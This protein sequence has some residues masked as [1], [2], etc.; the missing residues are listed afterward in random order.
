MLRQLLLPRSLPP[1][2]TL[3]VTLETTREQDKSGLM[4]PRC[5]GEIRQ[6]NVA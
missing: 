5:T 6:R 2:L 4:F 1:S 3:R